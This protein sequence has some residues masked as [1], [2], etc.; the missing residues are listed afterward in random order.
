MA[1]CSDVRELV[2]VRRAGPGSDETAE[3]SR[4]TADSSD[5]A[6][7]ALVSFGGRFLADMVDRRHR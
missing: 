2:A 1:I 3:P 7:P 6:V 4:L 5:P